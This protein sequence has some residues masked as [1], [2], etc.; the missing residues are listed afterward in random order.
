MKLISLLTDWNGRG[1]YLAMVKARL[2]SLCPDCTL[3]DIS[4]SIEPFNITQAAFILRESFSS[5]PAGTVHIVGVLAEETEKTSHIVVRAHNQ[6]FIGADNGLFSLVFEENE[7]EVFELDI[8][9]DSFQ[10]TFPTYHR[11]LKAAVSLAEGKA[12]E[13]IA[14]K[15]EVW[16]KKFWLL[17]IVKADS[18]QGHV[19]FIDNYENLIVNID[20][21]LFERVAKGRPFVINLRGNKVEHLSEGYAGVP[22]GEIAVFF[23][24]SEYLEI[25]V[26]QGNA[27][28]LLGFSVNDIVRV[29]FLRD[30]EPGREQVKLF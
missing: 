21:T 25:A 14:V 12:V 4:H 1:Y 27:A 10:Q 23:N 22:E 9:A 8:P 17:P 26:N 5:F 29:E 15:T 18:I 3:L 24:V 30:D 28:S 19:Q 13:E 11:F 7:M 2:Y 20:R 16:K 6:Y